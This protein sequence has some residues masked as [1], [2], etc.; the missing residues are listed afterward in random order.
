MGSSHRG[1]WFY[2]LKS[3]Q[4]FQ[5]HCRSSDQY[6]ARS[7]REV[8]DR[9]YPAKAH[10]LEEIDRRL[11]EQL[12]EKLKKIESD[13]DLDSGL[14]IKAK[15]IT[16]QEGAS[17]LTLK[18]TEFTSTPTTAEAGAVFARDEHIH[19]ICQTRGSIQRS[20]EYASTTTTAEVGIGTPELMSFLI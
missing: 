14:Q 4:R 16:K 12:L 18:S 1:L 15:S 20:T 17:N 9:S 6:Q 8:T 11:S 19:P 7:H 2:Y 5:D 13:S 3:S 10:Q